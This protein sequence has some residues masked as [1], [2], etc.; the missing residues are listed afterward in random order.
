MKPVRY[1]TAPPPPPPPT[2]DLMIV[3]FSSQPSEIDSLQPKS[4][5]RQTLFIPLRTMKQMY[6][7]TYVE[8]NGKDVDVWQ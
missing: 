2:H 6:R 3:F 8:G 7:E 5:G 4:S 1:P